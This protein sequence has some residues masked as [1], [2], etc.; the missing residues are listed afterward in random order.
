MNKV[1]KSNIGFVSYW[2]NRGQAIVTKY[3]KAIFDEAGYSTYVLVRSADKP[4]TNIGDWAQKNIT[5][6]SN[7]LNIDLSVYKKWIIDNEINVIFFDQ[8]YQFDEILEIRKM[9]VK[10]IGRFVWE[11]FDRSHAAGAKKSYDLIYSL[12]RAEHLR[13]KSDFNINSTF[14]RWGIPSSL[15][16]ITNKVDRH[17]DL[18][19]FYYPAGYCSSRKSLKETIKA[20]SLVK[21]NNIRLLIT[22]QKPITGILDNRIVVHYGDVEKYSDFLKIMSTCDICIIP[23][24]WEGLGLSFI[25][26]FSLK[27]PIITTNY[28][29]M[30]EYVTNGAD[31]Y[32]VKCHLN[33]KLPNGLFA[34][35][36]DIK[37]LSRIISI[38]A[39]KS[40]VLQMSNYI[41]K[42]K[43]NLYSWSNTSNDYLRL[44]DNI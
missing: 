27:M 6:G 35:D 7:K 2:F 41:E 20:F 33:S 34:A 30:N 32:L 18:I 36:I 29:P 44:L 26:S 12:T 5:I 39:D 43:Q 22:T 19:W 38:S 25:E 8:N 23:S 9:G 24:R 4:G 3:V 37:D 31:G 13:Y 17:D 15:F 40:K 10:T 16:G 21:N 11:E 14:I 28:P 42:Y 1:K